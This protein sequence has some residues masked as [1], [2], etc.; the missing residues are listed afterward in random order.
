MEHGTAGRQPA[1]Q[2][3]ADSSEKDV[4]ATMSA[5]GSGCEAVGL[6]DSRALLA[7]LHAERLARRP[8][9]LSYHTLQLPPPG[10]AHFPDSSS[11]SSS[12]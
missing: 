1:S 6:D 4:T 3:V 8:P 2:P 7:Q 9:R 10:S 11:S 12:S 5:S